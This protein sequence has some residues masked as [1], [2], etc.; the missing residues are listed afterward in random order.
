MP[1]LGLYP[2]LRG[3]R[4]ENWSGTPLRVREE[5]GERAV[6]AKIHNNLVTMLQLCDLLEEAG[7]LLLAS[8][9]ELEPGNELP[10]VFHTFALLLLPS[11]TSGSSKRQ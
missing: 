8:I 10:K 2:L 7:E 6:E 9:T 3:E 5:T 11:Y 4:T 1:P